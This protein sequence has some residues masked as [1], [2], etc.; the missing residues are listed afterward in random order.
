[1]S[2]EL[3]TSNHGEEIREMIESSLQSIFIISPFMG[4]TTC[5][6]LARCISE[7]KIRCKIITRFYR[8]DFIQNVS[9]LEGLKELIISGA[10]VY[11]LVGLHTKLY[12]IDSFY[13]I[14]TSAN[15]TYG[16]MYNNFELGVKID[17]EIE[18]NNACIDYF[19]DLWGKIE[20]YN[21]NNKDKGIVSIELIDR[22]MSIINQGSA[23]RTKATVN[24]NKTKQGAELDDLSGTDLIEKALEEKYKASIKAELGGWLKFEADAQH[25]HDPNVSYLESTNSFTRNKTFFPTKP[26]GIKSNHKLFL[27]LVS[28]D[29]DHVATPVIVGRGFSTGFNPNFVISGKFTGWESWMVNYP[30]YVELSQLELIKGPARNGISLLELYRNV[31]GNMYPSTFGTNIPFERI[32]QYHYQ[33]DK[34]RITQYA[35]DY[36]DKLLEVKFNVFGK[37]YI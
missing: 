22:E 18:I 26:V 10:E 16:G 15:Y 7:N 31:K 5:K 9:S 34:I 20:R 4:K 13:S 25:R 28:Y 36:I 27:A 37:E 3:I 6:E 1:M 11:A 30:Y 12:I 2:V 23:S 14:I 21:S 35:E 29:T 17:N 24:M 8:E 19:N 33:K 32:R